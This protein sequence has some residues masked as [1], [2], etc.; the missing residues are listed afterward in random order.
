VPVVL[1]AIEADL[2]LRDRWKATLRGTERDQQVRQVENLALRHTR[3]MTPFKGKFRYDWE[4]RN[5]D[6][7]LFEADAA[8]SEK[9]GIVE[10]PVEGKTSQRA[11]NVVLWDK[12]QDAARKTRIA[13]LDKRSSSKNKKAGKATPKLSPA[14]QAKAE[15][16]KQLAAAKKTAEGLVKWRSRM[17]RC[18]VANALSKNLDLVRMALPAVMATARKRRNAFGTDPA[19]LEAF[20]R[21]AC[22]EQAHRSKQQCDPLVGKDSHQSLSLAIT[23]CC[24]DPRDDPTSASEEL[25]ATLLQLLIW[26]QAE[27]ACE[28]LL[29]GQKLPSDWQE[30]TSKKRKA[31]DPVV[32]LEISAADV[33]LLAKQCNVSLADGWKRGATAR[34]REG[35]LIE[36]FLELHTREQINQLAG[37]LL[38]AKS[39]A[40]S[41][42]VAAK[43][44][45]EAISYLLIEHSPRSPL[46]VPA[47]LGK[48]SGTRKKK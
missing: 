3:S 14:A 23:L 13:E 19:P 16:A 48:A 10:M 4:V 32:L 1:A 37:E 47:S 9:L 6:D 25:Q 5:C 11:T 20:F 42:I 28:P 40:A 41:Q 35:E 2:A 15:Q 31:V 22:I 33:E 46:K 34:S 44:R 26:P 29:I 39:V 38:G 21:A 12:L 30:M 8:T 43:T 27:V 45:G 7:V 24:A 36:E 17:L 18:L